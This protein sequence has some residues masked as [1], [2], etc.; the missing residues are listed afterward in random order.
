MKRNWLIGAAIF[1][2]LVLVGLIVK[3]KVLDQ[4]AAGALS[5]STIP[6]AAVFLDEAELGMT[7]FSDK[8]I[9]AGEYR[10]RLVPEDQTLPAWESQITVQSGSLTVVKWNFASTESAS[11][12]EAVWLEKMADKE[13]A[14]LTVVS[15]PD[16]AVVKV[17][18]QPRGFAPLLLEDLAVGEYQVMIDSL[19]YEEKLITAKTVAGYKLIINV[20]LAQQ[21]ENIQIDSEVDLTP[22]PEV[23]IT[24]TP[25]PGTLTPSPKL[26]PKP[27]QE[28]D[29]LARPYVK[30][31]ETGTG[32]LRVRATPGGSEVGR[33]DVGQAFPYLNEKKDVWLKIEYEPG[34]EGW[35]SGAYVD[36]FE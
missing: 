29:S 10:L 22:T 4:P 1:L 26:T 16:Q 28:A 19:G 3:T 13:E 23:E 35:V 17:N 18:G 8:K 2:T 5:V 24:L 36:L 11:S 27:T 34:K 30:I 33:V 20:Q 21:I 12:G 32:W 7:P 31:K 9:E 6:K 15:L 25:S 14:A